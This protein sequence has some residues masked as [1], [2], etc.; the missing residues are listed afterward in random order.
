MT[1]GKTALVIAAGQ[2]IGAACARLLAVQGW[3]VGLMS[4]SG[5][6]ETLARELGG[7]ARRG[8]LM[9]SGDM[10]ALIDMALELTGRIDAVVNNT[11]H[12]AGSSGVTSGPSYDPDREYHL[13][14]ISDEEWHRGLDL[15][16]LNV[17]R[18]ARLVTPVLR[19]QG[20]GAI[21]NISSFGAVE[22]RPE[23]PLSTLRLAL[24]GFTKLYADRHARD[25]IRMN[26]VL[27]GFV[28]NWP[29][30]EAVQRFTPIGRPVKLT[31]IAETVA[32]LLSDGAGAITGQNILVD[33]GIGRAVR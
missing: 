28:E 4:P 1:A 13:L 29:L 18:M 24:H 22:P 8:S 25:G 20:G 33:G 7:F 6:C 5:A 11:G 12:G 16:L 30:A 27:P 14:D 21:V 3:Q 19:R 10:Q 2:G 9:D 26:N 23:Y 31:E 32:F 15:Y 17:V